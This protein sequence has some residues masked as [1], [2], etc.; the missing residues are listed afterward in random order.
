MQ[1]LH[2]SILAQ[3]ALTAHSSQPLGRAYAL[4]SDALPDAASPRDGSLGTR[5]VAVFASPTE[6]ESMLHA[7]LMPSASAPPER[8]YVVKRSALRR[9][10]RIMVTAAADRILPAMPATLPGLDAEELIDDQA[11][12]A[13][14]QDAFGL[15]DFVTELVALCEQTALP[16]NVALFGAWGSGKSSLANLLEQALKDGNRAAVAFARFD[17][18]KYAGLALRRHLLS[19]LAE[20]LGIDGKK[21]SEGLYR[22]HNTNTYELPAE[23]RKRFAKLLGVAGILVAAVLLGTSAI[24]GLIA[25]GQPKETFSS[26]FRS[27]LEG[28][29]P[30][31]LFASGLIATLLALAGKTF[32][33]ESTQA[34]PSTEEEFGRLFSE[35][36]AEVKRKG[37]TRIVIFID[38]LDRCSP[39]QVVAVLETIKTF[40]HI[41][42]CVFVVAADKQAIEQ[43]LGEQARQATPEDVVNPY[44]SAGSAYLDK[45]FQH[46]LALPPLLPR[47]LSQ[48]AL[49]LIAERP[50]VWRG[51]ANKAE[52]V[53]VLVPEHVRS[54][55]RV[56]VL[57][58]AFLLA[59]RLAIRRAAD[60]ALDPD[61]ATRASEI[62]KL[63]CL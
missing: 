27:A 63:V 42:P 17:A 5:D 26:G 51:I 33:V 31:L 39:G 4:L 8:A 43:A 45:I 40:M 22:T 7:R 21:Y 62:A 34:P 1:G 12:T 13:A 32:I 28:G 6:P 48:F 50:G 41:P 60:G 24:V 52:L 61:V 10:S 53:T 30:A 15:N 59:Y 11:L 35:L 56:K 46:Q 20:A 57:L 49:E 2:Q 18:F 54:P 9:D 36:V 3:T 14:G 25:T 23:D 29:I 58:N 16:A 38:E 19:Q 37:H 55:R 47:T 44:Y